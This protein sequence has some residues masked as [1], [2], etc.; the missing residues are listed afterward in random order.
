MSVDFIRLKSYENDQS[1]GE[2]KIIGLDNLESLHGN[3]L[4]F[5]YGFEK[6][7][8]SAGLEPFFSHN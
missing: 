4:V 2:I 3:K 1:S 6:L 8:I 7:L 5:Q